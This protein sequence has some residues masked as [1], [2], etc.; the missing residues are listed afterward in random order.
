MK[1]FFI[2]YLARREAVKES[3]KLTR[4][5]LLLL[6]TLRPK[7]VMY[8]VYK[9]GENIFVHIVEFAN[10]EAN[11]NFSLSPAINIFQDGIKKLLM[12][13]PVLNEIGL[14]GSSSDQECIGSS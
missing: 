10:E 3:E 8:S 7:G 11:L 2:H 9:M 13:E 1:G 5:M 12:E 6:K 14:I 4:E